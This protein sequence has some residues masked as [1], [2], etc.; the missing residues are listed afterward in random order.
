[1]LRRL[2]A[3]GRLRR[4][5]DPDPEVVQELFAASAGRFPCGE[6]GRVGLTIESVED[7]FEKDWPEIRTCSSCGAAIPAERVSLFPN[8]TLCVA[9][10]QMSERGG[11][12]EETEYCPKCG[13]PVEVRPT[14]GPGVTRY[15]MACSQCR[16]RNTAR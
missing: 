15:E 1:M 8:V 9:C 5:Q 6:C 4:A 3:I 2:H 16:W 10:Q 12:G 14:R 11:E 7:E 13:A